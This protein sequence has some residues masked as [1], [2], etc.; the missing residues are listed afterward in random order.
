MDLEKKRRRKSSPGEKK[1]AYKM[2]MLSWKE[3][4]QVSIPCRYQES[5]NTCTYLRTLHICSF[6]CL[7]ESRPNIISSNNNDKT[8]TQHCGDR[9][10]FLPFYTELSSHRQKRRLASTPTSLTG[11][12]SINPRESSRDWSNGESPRGGDDGAIRQTPRS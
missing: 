6:V 10:R 9:T 4:Y 5:R 2:C 8:T 1:N 12:V 11:N 7:S 3:R